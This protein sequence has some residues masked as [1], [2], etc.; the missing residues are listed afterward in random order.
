MFVEATGAGLVKRSWSAHAQRLVRTLVV[1]LMAPA[2]EAALLGGK[3]DR[4]R[5]GGL[6]F[7]IAVHALV[8]AVV[9]RRGR[10]A[11]LHLDALLDPPCA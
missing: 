9:L 2:L 8:G 6:G 7:E 1:E 4:G 10:P 3:I 11:E 5:L